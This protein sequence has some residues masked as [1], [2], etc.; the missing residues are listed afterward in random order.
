MTVTDAATRYAERQAGIRQRVQQRAAEL[1]GQITTGIAG[2]QPQAQVAV[3]GAQLAPREIP[4]AAALLRQVLEETGLYL[5]DYVEFPSRSALVAVLL[6]IAHAA[7]R[8][9]QRELIWWASP[10]LLLTSAENGSGKST[11]LDMIGLLLG[12]RAGRMVKV[13]PYGLAKVLGAYKEVALPD[14]AQNMFGATG[15]AAKDVQTILLGSYSR[16]GTWVSGKSKGTIEPVFGPV[17]IA[18]KDAVITKNAD[19]L[20]DLLARS[21]IVRM[22]RP[23]RYMRQMDR[24]GHA[25]GQALAQSLAAVTGA[26]QDTLLHVAE[27]LSR[28][29]VGQEITDGDGGRIAQIWNPLEAVA[30]VAGEMWIQAEAQAREELAAASGDLLGAESALAGI[31]GDRTEGRN[32]WDEADTTAGWE[33]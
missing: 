27:D 11:L 21:V 18:G 25:R 22:E 8:D 14:D 17:A 23:R 33:R 3:R 6:W 28:Q 24:A 2:P 12:S 31:V 15:E 1:R 9:S 32:F 19:A 4:D 13:T 7:A 26:L 30:Q 29:A 5:M 16:G 10:R 20:A